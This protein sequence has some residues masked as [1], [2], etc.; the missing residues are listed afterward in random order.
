MKELVDFPCVVYALF[1]SEFIPRDENLTNVEYA[2]CYLMWDL[3]DCL[4]K[5]L[6]VDEDTGED[7]NLYGY[8]NSNT[9]DIQL[10]TNEVQT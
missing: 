5:G 8:Y 7:L 3:Y 9:H 4:D 10:I 6:P 1:A 2:D